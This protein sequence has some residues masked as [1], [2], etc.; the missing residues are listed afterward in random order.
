M[1]KVVAAQKQI[2]AQ[3][4]TISMKIYKNL[5]WFRPKSHIPVLCALKIKVRAV[6]IGKV[7][8]KL[9]VGWQ[10]RQAQD[11]SSNEGIWISSL[12]PVSAVNGG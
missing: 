9:L 12:G 7:H 8:Q 4:K 3:V 2:G 5:Q 10:H 11:K 6:K 1:Q